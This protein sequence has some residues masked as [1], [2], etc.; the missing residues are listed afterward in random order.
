MLKRYCIVSRIKTQGHHAPNCGSKLATQERC[1]I[2][3]DLLQK[4]HIGYPA[5]L[6]WSSLIETALLPNIIQL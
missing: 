2:V 3:S 5:I 6:F 1:K 4:Y